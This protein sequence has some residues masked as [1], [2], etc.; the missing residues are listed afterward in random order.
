MLLNGADDGNP[1]SGILE[2]PPQAVLLVTMI[3]AISLLLVSC[4]LCSQTRSSSQRARRSLEH[5]S[6]PTRGRGMPSHRLVA[7]DSTDEEED[8]AAGGSAAHRRALAVRNDVLE[9]IHTELLTLRRRVDTLEEQ[10]TAMTAEQAL[11][12]TSLVAQTE[13]QARSVSKLLDEMC[14][15]VQ[16]ELA[17]EKKAR[18][19]SVDGLARVVQRELAVEEKAR[20]ESVDALSRMCEHALSRVSQVSGPPPTFVNL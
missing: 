5:Q 11:V 7:S 10:C 6:R 16:R 18:S 3:A 1:F 13:D 8:A 12:Q 9:V 14:E 19:E 4:C 17:V 20:K 15:V 2:A